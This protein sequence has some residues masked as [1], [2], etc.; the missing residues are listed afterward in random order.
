MDPLRLNGVEPGTF[1]GQ[2][3]GQNAHAFALLFDLQVVL[4]N[5]GTYHLAHMKGGVI[6]DEQPGGLA[7]RLQPLATP[8]QKLGGNGADR[9]AR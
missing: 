7:L 9:T 8:L 6:P 4:A 3:E 5:P 1:G 2:K